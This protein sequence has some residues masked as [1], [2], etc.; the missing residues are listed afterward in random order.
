MRVLTQSE[1]L[2]MEEGEEK[3]LAKGRRET[4]VA[5]LEARFGTVPSDLDERLRSMAGDRLRALVRAALSAK[6]LS[7]F[8]AE[9]DRT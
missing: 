7:E 1:E 4:L 3:G 2:A 9:V 5:L 8:L 6:E